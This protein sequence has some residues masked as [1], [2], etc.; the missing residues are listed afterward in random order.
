MAGM[1]HL[2]KLLRFCLLVKV[3]VNEVKHT[4]TCWPSATAI[5]DPLSTR[6]AAMSPDP[7]V[8]SA[9]ASWPL[10]GTLVNTD[11][12]CKKSRLYACAI[13]ISDGCRCHTEIMSV[14]KDVDREYTANDR[15]ALASTPPDWSIRARSSPSPTQ[16]KKL[17]WDSHS[18]YNLL[19]ITLTIQLASKCT[20]ESV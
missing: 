11:C 5:H 3:G 18:T 6:F 14:C 19:P 13:R 9:F 7:A 15:L 12:R 10:G 16:E 20:E 4:T 1:E 17:R 2:E 8:F